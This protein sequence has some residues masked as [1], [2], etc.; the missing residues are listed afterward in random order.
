MRCPYL[1][2]WLM[3]A[4]PSQSGGMGPV[5][6]SSSELAAWS[7]AAGVDLQP[8]EFGALRAAS[9]AYVAEQ[10]SPGDWPP[11][12]DPDALYDDDVVAQRLE[13][14]LSRLAG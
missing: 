14:G 2:G 5:P 7:Q 1:W 4:G 11:Y 3:D 6:L 9:R 10:A 12:G 8:W 13:A